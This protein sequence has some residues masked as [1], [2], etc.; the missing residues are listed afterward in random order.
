[1]DT[2]LLVIL[3]S[4]LSAGLLAAGL[5]AGYARGFRRGRS[6]TPEHLADLDILANVGRAIL[7][8]QLKLDALCEIVYQQ[9]N[10]IA[11]TSDFQIGLFEG[12][13]YLIKVWV[14]HGERLPEIRFAGQANSGLVGHVRRTAQGIRVG[15][16]QRE[17]DTLP[18]RPAYESV[19][20][21]RSALFV[22]MIA[23]GESIGV[24]AVQS[25]EADRYTA[26]SLRLLT[27]LANQAA[28]AIHNAQLYAQ[29][30]ERANQLRVISELSRRITTTQSLA[31]LFRQIVNLVHEQFGYYAVNIFT[32]DERTNEVRLRASSHEEFDRRSLHL[33]N[34]E[35]LVGWAALNAQ[36]VNVSDV[37]ADRR[38][39][40]VTVLEQ[41]RSEFC[42]PLVVDR[43]VL[44]VLDV[45]SNQPNA[46]KTEDVFMLESL[47]G[48]LALAVQEAQTYDAERRQAERI[49]AMAEASRAVVSILDI[50]DL[51]DEVVDLVADYFG[52]DRVHLFLRV[53]DKVVFRSGS[54]A[55]SA[56]WSIEQLAYNIYDNGFIPWVARTGQA[57]VSGD[58]Q[59]DQRYV[60]G[61]GLEDSRSEMTVPITIG[62]HVLGVFDIQSPNPDDFTPEDVTL[63]Q[64]LA[65]TVAIG[66]RNASLFA[67]ETRRRVLA[68]TLRDVSEALVSSRDVKSVLDELLN[69]LR[70]V[71]DHE[72]ALIA[73]L[74]PEE[75][76]Y[77]VRAARGELNEQAVLEQTFPA[78]DQATER[79]WALLRL[80]QT[81]DEALTEN[82][83]DRL[84]APMQVG[85]REIGLLA[86]ERVTADQFDD[87]DIKIIDAFA[88]QAAL[89]IEVAQL[90]AA[91]EEEAWV[92]SALLSVAEA[93]SSTLELSQMLETLV[94]LT[95]MLVDV[96]R[97]GILAWDAELKTLS[98]GTARGLEP[99]AITAFRTLSISDHPLLD[100]LCDC[101]EP[102][103]VGSG[104]EHPL[105]EDLVRLFGMSTLW[106]MPL[107]ARGVLVGAMFVDPPSKNGDANRRLNILNGIAHQAA[108]ALQ[109]ARLQAESNE[110]QRLERELDVAQR[111]QRSF[112]PQQLPHL[113]GW[114]IATFYRAARQIGGDFYDFIPLKNGKWGIVIADVADKGVPAALFMALCRTNI[115]AAAFSRDDP[116]ETLM[117]VNELLLSDS[118]SDMFVTVWYGVWDA[119]HG[120]ITYANCGH[121]PPLLMAADG[122]CT[123]LTA[124]GIA[125]GVVDK[126][127]LEKKSCTIAPGD[128]L[129]AYTDGITDALRSD[130]TEFGLIGL[131]STL[132]HHRQRTATEIE[133]GIVS[134][135]DNFTVSEPQFDDLTLI[136]IKRTAQGE[137]ARATAELQM[138][139]PDRK[140]PEMDE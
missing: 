85:G 100:V 3:V 108:L 41:T 1:M 23:G 128:V 132:T 73:L 6:A 113:P 13:D 122:S 80:M 18:A 63:V 20:P 117:R 129:V 133:K 102:I 127:K 14:R 34:G 138:M 42:A 72:A 111:I 45:Q 83:G 136:V 69:S 49:N 87:E 97:C 54:G 40:P 115:R 64:A 116:A 56:R 105:P 59:S 90:F 118:R 91:K 107:V 25:D 9:A 21:P 22:P 74:R 124:K 12:D 120:E 126:I 4:L 53:G 96:R 67:V 36:T 79:L 37:S 109:T 104:T 5:L 28:G 71:V 17:W 8:A 95:L 84:F 60:V 93:M 2:P 112:L 62:N 55:H 50:N 92:T 86:L 44:G 119:V 10:K 19:N 98:N 110:R 114:Q 101:V 38:Y 137:L 7:G 29:A 70:Q 43:R 121:N 123:E 106:V 130:G 11:D 65:D 66:M 140:F 125:L 77:I 52:Y 88:N 31:N 89:A 103:T 75:N 99:S 15:D 32:Y 76:D 139:R 135:L 61:M 47:A 81:P 35:G 82:A 16:F 134:A 58:V 48:Q 24:I 30:R 39:L 78:D 33:K 57:L 131:H 94:S 51:L 27:L 46:F 68:E 26:E